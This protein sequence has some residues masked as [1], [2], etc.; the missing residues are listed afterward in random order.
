[1]FLI[2]SV[3]LHYLDL[4]YCN[5]MFSYLY[6]FVCIY[7]HTGTCLTVIVCF[8]TC[9]CSYVFTYILVGWYAFFWSLDK[10]MFWLHNLPALLFFEGVSPV[11][12]GRSRVVSIDRPDPLW[13]SLSQGDINDDA[14]FIF[15]LTAPAPI[16]V[17]NPKTGVNDKKGGTRSGKGNSSGDGARSQSGIRVT[18]REGVGC[19]GTASGKS[20]RLRHTLLHFRSTALHGTLS[21]QQINRLQ[22]NQ[23]AH[24]GRLC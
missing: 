18:D 11:P 23:G 2:R 20:D 1:V 14:T 5:C 7:L 12:F 17:S 15:P 22:L 21:M 24:C 3:P 10:H 8:L 6:L 19:P 4:P 13:N 16:A 9:I